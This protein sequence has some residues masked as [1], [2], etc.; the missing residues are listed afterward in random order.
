ML[1]IVSNKKMKQRRGRVKV[2]VVVRHGERLDY[3]MRDN[4]ENWMTM[5]VL[6]NTRSS[7]SSS[8][9]ETEQQQQQQQQQ[10]HH[11]PLWDPPLTLHGIQTAQNLGTSLPSILQ[12]YQLPP[13]ITAIYSS[14]FHRCRQTATGIIDG[15]YGD[16][17]GP[18]GDCQSAS[19]SVLV[20]ND[21]ADTYK[22]TS[23]EEEGLQLKQQQQQQA[24][25]K[26]KVEIGLVESL[27]Q[28]WYRSWAIPGTD[29]TWGYTNAEC[30]KMEEYDPTVLHPASKVPVQQSVLD[31][32]KDG[33]K[34]KNTDTGIDSDSTVRMDVAYVSQ[35]TIA[36][37][38]SLVPPNYENY[39]QQRQRMHKT[40]ELLSNNHNWDETIVLVSHGTYNTTFS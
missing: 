19:V 23:S 15:V 9:T 14:P 25:L 38:Y 31:W 28:N 7:S 12:Q 35:S 40:M 33:N 5:D 8:T 6:P 21:C 13:T 27:N 20:D 36:A 10:Q 32:N 4:G 3:V 34:N 37:P 39:K 1:M 16:E 26:V 2:V 29:G 24:E 30:T 17:N 22:A 18:R 11:R